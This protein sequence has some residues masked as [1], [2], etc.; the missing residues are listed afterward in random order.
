[1]NISYKRQNRAYE[2]EAKDRGDAGTDST[3]SCEMKDRLKRNL[4]ERQKRRGTERRTEK[5]GKRE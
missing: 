1:M 3:K 5:K 2:M 4:Q